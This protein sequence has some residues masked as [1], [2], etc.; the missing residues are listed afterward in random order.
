MRRP[1]A[2]RVARL[3]GLAAALSLSALA[4]ATPASA[5]A[6]LVSTEPGNDAVVERTPARVSLRFNEP[7]E[8]AFGAI[9]VYD[10]NA[11]RVDSGHVER[12][13]ADT[14]AV[15]LDGRLPRGTYTVTWRVVSADSHPVAGAFVFHVEAPGARPTGIAAQVLDS[16]SPASV[17]VL[18]TTVRFLDFALLL[19][20]AGGTAALALV[21]TDAGAVSRRLAGVLAGLSFGLAVAALAGIVLQG[22]VAAGFG[23]TEAFRWEVVSSVLETRFGRVW[24]AQ[25]IGAAALG[26]LALALRRRDGRG[27]LPEVALL[28]GAGLLLTPA[29]AGHASVS[30]AIA[31]VA[32]VAHVQAGAAWTGGLAFLVLGLVWAG[33]ERWSL[34]A[35]AV[36]RFSR[37]AVAAVALLLLAGIVNGYLQVRAWEGLWETTY[38]LLLLAKVA[39]VLPLLALGAYNNRYAV[40]RLRAGIASALERRRFLRAAGLELAL[41]AAVVGVTA[42]LVTEPPARAEVAP[43]GPFATAVPLGSLELDLVVD[44]AVAGANEIHLYLTDRNGQPTEVAEAAVSATLPSRRI[45]PLRLHAHRGGPGHYVVAGA[46]L[47]IGGD[48]QLTIEARRGEFESLRRT[49]SVP[50]R[51]EA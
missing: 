24:L 23:L 17:T 28:V 27:V 16:G 10:T 39:L 14:V 41:M 29:L 4:A 37:L 31:F 44:P 32:D 36:P 25:A 18:F 12:P 11:R 42:V 51:K 30:G 15:G 21:L 8:T 2:R 38:G 49:V 7:V 19:L 20:A 45:G 22:A 43:E 6:V 50:I 26:G 46:R 13:A 33:E 35:R 47:A 3:L 1:C 40:P 5:H 34:A 48:W 9:R